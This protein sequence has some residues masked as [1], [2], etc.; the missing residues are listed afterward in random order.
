MKY[1][2]E[3]TSKTGFY[4]FEGNYNKWFKEVVAMMLAYDESNRASFA[5]IK[6]KIDKDEKA[7]ILELGGFGNFGNVDINA[8]IPIGTATITN[9]VVKVN[10]ENKNMTYNQLEDMNRIEQLANNL[11][12]YLK[13]LY[14]RAKIFVD[15]ATKF[16]Q[17]KSQ[18][19]G[20]IKYI[21]L[22]LTIGYYLKSIEFLEKLITNVKTC[23]L[24]NGD[25]IDSNIFSKLDGSYLKLL[26]E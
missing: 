7:L 12:F 17:I 16:Y 13:Y 15:M 11:Q 2:K 20:A 25:L 14:N 6:E 3:V 24:P 1:Q 4:V 23:Q 9:S 26:T 19:N 21:V 18:Y 5:Q 8:N 10:P 22:Y